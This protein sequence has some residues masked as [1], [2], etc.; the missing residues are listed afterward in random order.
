MKDGK[1]EIQERSLFSDFSNPF[2]LSSPTPLVP[3]GD[4]IRKQSSYNSLPLP[5]RPE[6]VEGKRATVKKDTSKNK[7]F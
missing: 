3:R 4:L 1:K 6:P 2:A 5:V 7:R